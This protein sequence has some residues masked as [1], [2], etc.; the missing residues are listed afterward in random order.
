[1]INNNN[2]EDKIMDSTGPNNFLIYHRVLF[3]NSIIYQWF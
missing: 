1:M 2:G 3:F